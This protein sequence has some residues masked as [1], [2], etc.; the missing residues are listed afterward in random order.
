MSKTIKSTTSQVGYIYIL[1]RADVIK[2]GQYIFKIGETT[3]YPPH[4]RL[5][6]YPHGSIFLSLFKATSPLK[7]ESEI[8]KALNI[9]PL[10]INNHELGVEYFSGDL[11]TIIDIILKIYPKYKSVD[12]TCEQIQMTESYLLKLNRVHYLVNY[13]DKYFEKVFKLNMFCAVDEI[14]SESIHQSYL[15]ARQWNTLNYPDNYTIPKGTTS[16]KSSRSQFN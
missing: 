6:D 12:V 8:K 1:M 7:F 5:W 10:I 13:N 14:S 16:I 4:K 11:Q 15:V 2:K 3:R 9:S